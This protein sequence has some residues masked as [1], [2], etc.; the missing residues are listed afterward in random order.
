[1]S[2]LMLFTQQK[3]PGRDNQGLFLVTY[4]GG[5]VKTS[6][7]IP[8]PL[9]LVDLNPVLHFSSYFTIVLRVTATTWFYVMAYLPTNKTPWGGLWAVEGGTEDITHM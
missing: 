3:G 2:A 1:M 5:L 8:G 6:G 4:E 9:V 7:F